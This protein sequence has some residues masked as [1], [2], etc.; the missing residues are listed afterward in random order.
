MTISPLAL[1]KRF[2]REERGASLVEYAVLVA[3]V[4]GV[5][6][7]TIT[8]MGGQIN[9]IF[10]NVSASLADAITATAP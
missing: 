10:A 4:T 1:I 6:V 8:I 7:A 5:L 9:T 3:L 2:A